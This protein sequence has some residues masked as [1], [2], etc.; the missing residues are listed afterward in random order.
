VYRS[1]DL[2]RWTPIG[3]VITRPGQ[4]DAAAAPT[5]GGVW[6]PTIRWRDGVFHVVVATAGAGTRVYSAPDPAGPWSDGI[7][8]DGLNGIDPDLAWDESGACY[9]TFSGLVLSGDDIGAHLGIQQVRVDPATFQMLEPPRPLWS[10]TGGMFPEAPHLYRIGVWWYLLIAEGGTERGHAVT[11]ARSGSPA[12]PFEACPHNPLVTARGTSRPIQNTGHGDLVEAPDG[13]WSM[14]L[15]GV[16]VRG[17]TRSFSAHGRETFGTHV[18]WVDGW[19]VVDPV[20]ADD[21]PYA[22]LF[23]DDFSEPDVGHE[24]IGVRRLPTDVGDRHGG[25][26]VLVG[27]GRSMNHPQPTFV[28]R[29]QRRHDARISAVVVD[30]SSG[31]GGLTVRYDED[32]HYDLEVGHG[33]ITARASLPSL[34]QEWNV[35]VP[36]GSVELVFEMHAVD[37]TFGSESGTTDGMKERMACDMIGFVAVDSTGVRHELARVDGRFLSAESACSFTG[38][39]AGVYCESGSLAFGRYAEEGLG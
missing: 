26:L 17:L 19:P 13:T 22:P 9:V 27:E 39:V 2:V 34:R 10:G 29:R 21:E 14:V 7:L 15:L 23:V 1:V 31:V 6:A 24:W 18:D 33:R 30:H 3:H 20:I 5:G 36:A 37:A 4:F 25:R 35:P 32:H 12:G 38:R 28:G 11:I 16:R 8:I